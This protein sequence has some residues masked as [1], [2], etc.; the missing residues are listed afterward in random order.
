MTRHAVS[1]EG[2]CL[3]H[4]SRNAGPGLGRSLDHGADA[5]PTR[6]FRVRGLARVM[7]VTATQ[8]CF[9]MLFICGAAGIAAAGD[10]TTEARVVEFF[11]AMQEGQI[12]VRFIAKNDRAANILIANKSREPL[13]VKLPAAFAGVPVLAQAGGNVGGNFGGGGGGATGGGGSQGLG[14]GFGGGLG[15]GGLGGGG[16][17]NV[18]PEQVAKV[19]VPCVCLDHGKPDPS[20]RIPYVIQPI[21]NYVGRPAVIELVKGFGAGQIP[22]GAAQAAVWHLNNDVSWQELAR[23]R[24]PRRS[25]LGPKPPYFS[26]QQLHL[27]VRAA[28]E[29]V[30]R[31][32]VDSS[33]SAS[34][35]ATQSASGA[36]D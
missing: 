32:K 29:A 11:Q 33:Q 31:S 21:E 4:T 1:F 28:Q 26:P 23:K 16:F 18:A 8:L 22:H 12:D 27:A 14:G 3:G 34:A 10:R 35:S 13:N 36:Y 17:F 7:N 20:P 2:R 5:Q 15:G 25:A 9:V 24:A 6:H 19:S 30:R